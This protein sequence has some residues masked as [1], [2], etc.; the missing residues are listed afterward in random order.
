MTSNDLPCDENRFYF[1]FSA[2]YVGVG[3]LCPYLINIF[4]LVGAIFSWGVMWPLINAR[5]G[6]WYAVD[7][8]DSSLKG[9]QGYRVFSS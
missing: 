5:K 4:V 6:D 8:S 9:V 3:M 7:L 2:V 1:D